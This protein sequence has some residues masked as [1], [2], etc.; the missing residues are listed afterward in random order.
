MQTLEWKPAGTQ[1]ATIALNN[2]GEPPWTH[3]V[4]ITSADK[5]AECVERIIE[6]FPGLDRSDIERQLDEIAAEL[7]KLKGKKNE[8]ADKLNGKPP[9][10]KD[11]EPWPDPVCGADLLDELVTTIRRF[12]ILPEYGAEAAALWIVHAHAL[13]AFQ[14]SPFL[15]LTS[16]ERRCGKTNTL[17]ILLQLAPRGAAVSNITGPALF[18]VIEKFQ[19]TLG[20]DEAETYVGPENE[21]LRGILDSGHTRMTA[22]VWRCVGDDKEA[23]LFSTWCPKIVGLIGHLAPTLEDRSIVLHLKRKTRAE[24]VDRLRLD[25]LGEFEP[26]CSRCARWTKDN[27]ELLREADPETPQEI[28][29]DRALDNWRPLLAIADAVGEA[30]PAR[31]RKAARAL[32]GAADNE[33]VRVLL[34]EDLRA[35]FIERGVERLKT[36]DIIEHLATLEVHPWAEWKR[37]KPL[38]P[39]GM[40]RLLKPFGITPD[41]W[42]DGETIRGYKLDQ[43]TETFARYLGDQNATPATTV[44]SKDN[45][46]NANATNEPLVASRETAIPLEDHGCGG[47]GGSKPLTDKK[48]HVRDETV[49][50]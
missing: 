28:E 31:A 17:T 49:E 6:R 4:K 20:L 45:P 46:E 13:D 11:P 7:F 50:V 8:S 41:K 42:R 12:S 14:V 16:P 38:S 21:Q 33:S 3:T 18:R 39:T 10:L 30:W 24:R 15:T 48:I 9:V 5:R 35:L 36:S 26:L 47:C 1:S 22:C 32:S 43:F 27:L 19:P 44:K 25:R 40:A 37:G 34:L 23:A 2:D 29:N